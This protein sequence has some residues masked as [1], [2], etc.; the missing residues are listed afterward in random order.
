MSE[1]ALVDYSELE[2]YLKN[3]GIESFVY[4]QFSEIKIIGR[5]GSAIVY[6][7]IFQKKK[8]VLKSL[9]NNLL[10]DEKRFKQIKREDNREKIIANTPS[11]YANLIKECWSS[12]PDQRPTLDQIL[13]ELEN[14]SNKTTIEFITN[15]NIKNNQQI[16]QPESN[17]EDFFNYRT[18]TMY[19]RHEESNPKEESQVLPG[20]HLSNNCNIDDKIESNNDKHSNDTSSDSSKL[21]EFILDNAPKA[22]NTDMQSLTS[23]EETLEAIRTL[24]KLR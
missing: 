2:E 10:L 20:S 8:Y 13:I 22:S 17:N 1:K 16:V 21:G 19:K 3:I 6:L 24:S 23:S 4:S 14:L 15:E 11:D 9:N 7:T 12:D 5:G 18:K